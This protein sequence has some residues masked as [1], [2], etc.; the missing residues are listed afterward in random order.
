MEAGR[1]R[2]RIKSQDYYQGNQEIY[3]KALLSAFGGVLRPKREGAPPNGIRL[4]RRETSESAGNL[5]H[6]SEASKP[7]EQE[8]EKDSHCSK[9]TTK[10]QINISI[11]QNRGK[12]SGSDGISRQ[13][14]LISRS[15]NEKEQCDSRLKK[16]TPKDENIT[17]SS[18]KEASESSGSSRLIPAISR[19]EDEAACKLEPNFQKA[20][21]EKE[22]NIS[23]HS[24]KEASRPGSI[25]GYISELA[26]VEDVPELQ[27]KTNF[28][29]TA[30]REEGNISKHNGR[31]ASRTGGSL[32][33]IPELS[34]YENDPEFQLKSYFQ[35]APLKKEGNNSR[36]SGKET[37]EAGSSSKRI[38]DLTEFKDEPALQQEQISP[39]ITAKE[40]I[41]TTFEQSKKRSFRESCKPDSSS[42][43]MYKLSQ[44]E[45]KQK[46][47]KECRKQQNKTRE[48]NISAS[49]SEKKSW[50]LEK[51]SRCMSEDIGEQ[52]QQGHS[53]E[54]TTTKDTSNCTKQKNVSREKCASHSL[55]D[56]Q[57][58]AKDDFVNFQ[59]TVVV[60]SS[61]KHTFVDEHDSD[62]SQ[63]VRH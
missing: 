63:K 10:E 19:F 1:G 5:K 11:S 16:T 21:L 14:S 3:R 56:S 29:K 7:V 40:G 36:Q 61:P 18:G 46:P 53:R 50:R 34:G 43:Y 58:I 32:R 24:R 26:T 12:S 27:Q 55:F 41:N 35:K 30:A 8:S 48:T 31:E 23:R 47:E 49:L 37:S 38:V 25:S 22:L 4:G 33:H 15:E 28:Q 60:A 39:K 45:E 9:T 42:K 6:V 20:A 2:R 51:Q 54:K 13:V 52:Y 17:R 59:R 44:T 57:S 62:I